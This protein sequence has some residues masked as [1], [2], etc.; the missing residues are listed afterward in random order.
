[1]KNKKLKIKCPCCPDGWQNFGEGL[2][3]KCETKFNKPKKNKKCQKK[4]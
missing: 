3:D 2:C 1:M 4:N